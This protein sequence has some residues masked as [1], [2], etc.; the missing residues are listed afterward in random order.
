MILRLYNG[1]CGS[2][3]EVSV[4]TVPICATEGESDETRRVAALTRHFDQIMVIRGE[5]FWK[6]I[7]ERARLAEFNLAFDKEV[8]ARRQS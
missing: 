2:G 8:E 3:I 5:I 1:W 7:L 6:S 4:S